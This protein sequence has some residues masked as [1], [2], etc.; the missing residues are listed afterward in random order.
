MP[1]GFKTGT[2]FIVVVALSQL[3]S[4]EAQPISA[5][6]EEQSTQDHGSPGGWPSDK[7]QDQYP[8]DHTKQNTI[9]QL[10]TV[11]PRQ[12]AKPQRGLFRQQR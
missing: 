4:G 6:G 5:K 1:S 12:A 7:T 10:D 11:P 9:D 8:A 2:L 3:P